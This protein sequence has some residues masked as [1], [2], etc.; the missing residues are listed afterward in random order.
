VLQPKKLVITETNELTADN[1][2]T[3]FTWLCIT[4][5]VLPLAL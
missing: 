1:G 2:C 5:C 4:L 3:Y